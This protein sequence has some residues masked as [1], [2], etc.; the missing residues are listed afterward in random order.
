[1][2]NKSLLYLLTYLPFLVLLIPLWASN[3]LS[4]IFFFL[5]EGTAV[6]FLEE[7]VCW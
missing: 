6:T 3:F 4:S 5:S 1:M 7:L 2:R